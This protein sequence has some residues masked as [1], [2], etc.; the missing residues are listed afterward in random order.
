MRLIFIANKINLVSGG[1]SHLSLDIIMRDLIARGHDATLITIHSDGNIWRE[2]PYY[3]KYEERLAGNFL[4]EL[5][6]VRALLFSHE[7]ECDLYVLYGPGFFWSGGMYRA[8]GGKRPTTAYLNNYTPAL[9]ML[10]GYTAWYRLKRYLWEKTFGLHYAKN[11]DGL[12]FVSPM[13]RDVYAR[14]GYPRDKMEVI[15]EFI[16][17]EKLMKETENAASHP[18]EGLKLLFIGRLI[19]EKGLDCAIAALAPIAKERKITL[20]VVGSGP[21]EERLKKMTIDLRLTPYIVFHGQKNQSDVARFCSAC[22]IFVH[23]CRWIE[24]FGRTIAEAM[25]FGKPIITTPESGSAWIAD[26]GGLT[27]RNGDAEDLRR[28]ILKLYDDPVLRQQRG[29]RARLRA[30]DFDHRNSII[31]FEKELQSIIN[32]DLL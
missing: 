20:D 4:E 28:I 24:P 17:N 8:K 1:G 11:I 5:G 31:I 14:F 18:H 13:I 9:G 6:A 26:G 32:N 23:P 22:D 27:F 19:S 16:E 2:R 7:E 30:R 21:E 29:E 25:V 12:L 10:G 3:L 15:H